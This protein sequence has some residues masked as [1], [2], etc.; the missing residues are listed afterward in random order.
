MAG[1]QQGRWGSDGGAKRLW[2]TESS[3]GDKIGVYMQEPSNAPTGAVL[4][5]PREEFV[6]IVREAGITGYDLDY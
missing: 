2:F 1:I 6:R 5:V 3:Y 4:M